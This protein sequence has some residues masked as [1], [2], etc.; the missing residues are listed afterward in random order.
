M[1]EMA[2]TLLSTGLVGLGYDTLNVVCNGWTGRD[3]VTQRLQENKALW[4]N[5]IKALGDYLHSKNMKL[6]C[7][8][9]PAVNNCC[10]EP[11]SLGY[12]DIDMQTFADWGCDHIMVDWCRE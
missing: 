11:G 12:E 9:S 4:P 5:G 6:G 1:R 10:G 2:D 8:T 3:P 7:Y